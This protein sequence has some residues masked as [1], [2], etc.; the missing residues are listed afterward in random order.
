M[1]GCVPKWT[2]RLAADRFQPDMAA[3]EKGTRKLWEGLQVSSG[4][5]H[6]GKVGG[7]VPVFFPLAGPIASALI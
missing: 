4:V 2:A 5:I 7:A 3:A 1:F 6:R